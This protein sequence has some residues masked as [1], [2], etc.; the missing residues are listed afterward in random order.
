MQTSLYIKL[1]SLCLT[2]AGLSLSVEAQARGGDQ[3]RAQRA[4][5][6]TRKVAHAP[7]R[8]ATPPPQRSSSVRRAEPAPSRRT[9]QA[10]SSRSLE[11]SSRTRQVERRAQRRVERRTERHV[12]R[13]NKRHV[14]RE[15]RHVH[16][17][18][19]F[20]AIPVARPALRPHYHGHHHTRHCGHDRAHIFTE[21][22]HDP[23]YFGVNND[24]SDEEHRIDLGVRDGRLTPREAR[25]LKSMLWDARALEHDALYD[26]L[27]TSEEEADLY[28]A[29]RELNR[30]IRWELNDFERW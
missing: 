16:R 29:E 19:P 20:R 4:G 12:R 11:R 9:A 25:R 18:R 15:R 13:S 24:F 30:E 14:R 3:P 5:S 26:G 27:L 8:Q 21:L 7:A 2:I 6:S 10:N 22:Y 23:V 28:W 17:S 1:T